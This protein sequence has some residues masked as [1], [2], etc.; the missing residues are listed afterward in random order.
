MSRVIRKTSEKSIEDIKNN[1]SGV[2]FHVKKMVNVHEPLWQRIAQE[3]T[4]IRCFPNFPPTYTQS[5]SIVREHRDIG[6]YESGNA[7]AA[8]LL[9]NV[10]HST[11]LQSLSLN[12]QYLSQ[13]L[14]ISLVGIVQIY[15]YYNT[16]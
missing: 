9:H 1:D 7:A 2:M 3:D 5:S 14:I 13:S 6:N 10:T 12:L 16:L 11:L 4:I 15:E 8:S